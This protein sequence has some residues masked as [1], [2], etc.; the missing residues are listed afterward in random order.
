MAGVDDANDD[1]NNNDNEINENENYN[2]TDANDGD[3][4]ETTIEDHQKAGVTMENQDKQ[5][6]VETEIDDDENFGIQALPE[7]EIYEQ[8]KEAHMIA[9]AEENRNVYGYTDRLFKRAWKARR[10]Q[11]GLGAPTTE[12]FKAMLRSNN[13]KDCPVIA[14][15]V[16]IAEDIFGPDV[17]TLKG[18]SKRRKP[19]PV[20]EDII[21][22]PIELKLKNQNMTMGMDLMFI[23]SVPFLTAI[24]RGPRYRSSIPLDSREHSE[25]LRAI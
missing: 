20:V 23:N 22:I 1:D 14:E 25:C 4:E 12:S 21:D 13:I 11:H 6:E 8:Y 24:D 9:S 17:A 19:E 16:R 5:E 15:D 7:D 10:L 3:E 18:K 2:Q